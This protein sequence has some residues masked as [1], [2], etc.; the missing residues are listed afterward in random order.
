RMHILQALI[1]A[2]NKID[3]VIKIIRGSDTT[4]QAKLRL[5]ERFNFD[6][7][8]AQ[9]IV[10]MQLKR[11]THLQIEDLQKEIRELQALIDHLEDLL[12]HHEKILGIIKDETNELADKYG[13]DRK[14]DI[15]A[16]E[17]DEINTED[18]IKEEEVVV[19]ISKMG[20]I[21]R[22]PLTQYKMQGKGGKGSMSANLIEDDYI[23]QIFIATTHTYI[24][25]ISSEGKAYWLKVHEIPEASRTSRGSSVKSLLQVTADEEITSIVTMKEYR[26]DQFIFMAT[27]NGVV[28]K[29]MITEFS[30]AKTR[31]IRAINLK[32]GDK[33]VSSILT[34]GKDDVLLITR[35]G[36]ALRI[37]EEDVR[38]MG[39]S[40]SGVTGIRLGSGDELAAAICVKDG[41]DALVI[42]E[43][44]IGKRVDFAEF[45]RHGRG[46]GGQKIFGNV[47]GK[48]EI[49]GAITVS[50]SD[51]VVC[52]SGQGKTLRVKAST[53]SKQGRGSSGTKIIDIESPDY[54]VGFDRIAKDD[55]D[56]K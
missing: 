56:E 20:Y 28:K 9:A 34:G 17:V 48:G 1:T 51:E 21:K 12:A 43:K 27:S 54:L 39:R 15:V 25:F 26:D 55:T 35:R 52:I 50:E 37:N 8:Q 45:G 11:L 44:G 6:D 7:E 31:G 3:E 40:S 36:Q 46:T 23:N 19:M 5:E 13:D 29:V 49:V 30:N 2:I 14:T 10:D 38:Q 47:D 32:D 41:H 4:E 42:T 18:M 22:V 33:L 16:D 53:I 24:T